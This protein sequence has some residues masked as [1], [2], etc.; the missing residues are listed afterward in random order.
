MSDLVGNPED[1]FSR[2]AAQMIPRKGDIRREDLKFKLHGDVKQNLYNK[3]QE[4]KMGTLRNEEINSEF[5][6][7]AKGAQEH[8]H[9][10]WRNFTAKMSN[11]SE[12]NSSEYTGIFESVNTLINDKN[13]GIKATTVTSLVSQEKRQISSGVAFSAYLGHVIT[14]MSIGFTIKCDQVLLNDGN[15]YSPYTGV[16]TVP[17]TG[18]YLLTFTINS[19]YLDNRL[20]VKLVSNNM[21]IVDVIASTKNIDHFVMA[22][23]TA[24]VRLNSGEK[25]WMEV[26]DTANV[27]L[28]SLR[29]YRWVTFS[30]ALL[31]A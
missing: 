4:E 22:G 19:A 27:H 11:L 28:Y 7:N 30:D 9:S 31:Y 20:H 8:K 26:Y 17:E 18:V 10:N 2:V 13:R 12:Q 16:F 3:H 23:N 6:A 29:D 1:R 21:N 14:N 25:V 15:A 24:I 5:A